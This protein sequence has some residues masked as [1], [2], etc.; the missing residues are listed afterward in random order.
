MPT[1]SEFVDP[2]KV[3][4]DKVASVTTMIGDQYDDDETTQADPVAGD[5][6]AQT[7]DGATD[8]GSGAV[9]VPE[10]KP[11]DSVEDDTPAEPGGSDEGQGD[12]V[13]LSSL[14]EHLG[15]D[16][17]D[18]YELEIPIADGNT[19]TLG[20]LKDEYKEYGPVKEYEA[21]LKEERSTYEKQVLSTRAEL[22]AIINAIP[23]DIRDQVI[24]AGRDHQAQW[25][26]DQEKAV[27][28]AIPEWADADQRAVDRAHLVEDGSI[29][30]FSESEITYTQDARTLRMLRDFSKMKREL[31]GMRTAAKA[32]PV[33]ANPPGKA[34]TTQS[35]KRKLAQAIGKAKAAPTLQ[36]KAGVVSQLIRNQ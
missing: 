4:A 23:Q 13:T 18:V 16:Q 26:R 24:F 11:T 2:V 31:S 3:Q 1:S 32:I 36:G 33:Q 20:Q 10:S 27:L 12:S 5:S 14:A 22:S 6:V 15:L 7:D 9:D 21:R 30:G 25:G 19:V 17:S 8:S 35:T 34:G 28:E 29:Y